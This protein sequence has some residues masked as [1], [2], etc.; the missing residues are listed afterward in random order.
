MEYCDGIDLETII[1]K[2][3]ETKTPM[4]KDFIMFIIYY[5]SKRLKEIH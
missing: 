1:N 2:Y 3:K 4:S 5:I